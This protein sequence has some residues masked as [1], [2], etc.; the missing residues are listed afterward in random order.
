MSNE[1]NRLDRRSFLQNTA[2]GLGAASVGAS[3]LKAADTASQP[4][5]GQENPVS[6][7]SADT[8]SVAEE[9]QQ[10]DKG[11]NSPAVPNPAKQRAQSRNQINERDYSVYRVDSAQQPSSNNTD[12]V[13]DSDI[14]V[15]DKNGT[16]PGKQQKG[17]LSKFFNR[18]EQ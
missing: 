17:F 1:H 4:S 13:E 12:D 2:A 6:P 5:A 18:D 16:P 15:I 14:R 9:A 7:N 8:P 10:K 3:I 11:V